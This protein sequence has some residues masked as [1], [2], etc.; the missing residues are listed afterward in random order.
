M[1]SLAALLLAGC[2][3][4]SVKPK[5][6]VLETP[7]A[8]LEQAAK[9]TAVRLYMWGGDEGVNEYVDRFVTPLLKEQHDITLE[10]IPIDTQDILQK[11]RVEKK[12]KKEVGVIDVVW[13]N[14][15]N[16]KNAKR[17]GL[18]YGDFV[19]ILPNRKLLDDTLNNDAGIATDGLEAAFGKVQFVVHY[20]AGRV[21]DAPRNLEEL[22]AWAADNPGRFTYPEAADFTGNAFIRHVMLREE[23]SEKFEQAWAYLN[24]IKPHLWK[25]GKTYPKTLAQLDRL[26]ANGDVWMTMGFNERRA[27]QEV[28]KGVFPK[29]TRALVLEEGSI[30]STHFLSVP[31]NAP[32]PSG[33]FVVIN[34]LLSP[35][36]QL[37]KY[38]STYWG[39]GTSLDL[40][41]LSDLERKAFLDVEAA[42]STPRASE[43]EGKVA[44][45]MNP[46]V[47]ERIRTEW[48]E[49]VAR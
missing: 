5:K 33:A 19:D 17:E 18:L 31:F 36:A 32:N 22:A 27:E 2:A 16:F 28:A 13:I 41:K 4:E 45:E 43:F 48:P 44:R 46:D 9:G 21:K 39:D 8:S 15:D 29:N 7:F 24:D 12:A 35:K 47:F 38:E 10:R 26:Y 6:D 34:E 30:A 20:D 40:D 37:A 23:G 3:G 42:A 14:G 1:A 11:L 49:Y 25:S